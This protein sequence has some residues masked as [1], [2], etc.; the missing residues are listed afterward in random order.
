M[1]QMGWEGR[2]SVYYTFGWVS[3][4]KSAIKLKGNCG[5]GQNFTSMIVDIIQAFRHICFS[6]CIPYL[7][8]KCIATD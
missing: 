2:I 4:V 6:N 3:K 5:R 7:N 1:A 8:V